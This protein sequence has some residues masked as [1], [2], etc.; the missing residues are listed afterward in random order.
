M[1]SM[2]RE[3]DMILKDE[4]PRLEI[5]IRAQNHPASEGNCRTL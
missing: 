1:N 3:K 5:L 4:L 2:K